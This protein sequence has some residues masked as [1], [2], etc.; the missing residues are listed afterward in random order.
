MQVT[1]YIE[2]HGFRRWYERQL[3]E[4]HAYLALGFV[5]LILLLSGMELLR[6][7]E[8]GIRY[9]VVL[10]TAAAGGMLL[11]VAWRRFGVLLARAE[12]FGEAAT[13]PQCNAWGKFR[14]IAQEVSSVDDPPEA[15]R[16]HWLQVRCKQ[17]EATWKLQ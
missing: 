9:A 13:C 5:A 17:C 11:V 8:A 7:A 14:V 16:P 1:R 12:H 6:D 2:R 3:I 15:G 4:S 10:S